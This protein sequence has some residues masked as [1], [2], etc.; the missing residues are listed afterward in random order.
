MVWPMGDRGTCK[1]KLLST[2]ILC[3]CN[4]AYVI[5]I[6]PCQQNN[7]LNIFLC[8][9]CLRHWASAKMQCQGFNTRVFRPSKLVMKVIPESEIQVNLFTN[10][11]EKN[12]TKFWRKNFADFCPLIFRKNGRKK[13]HAKSGTISTRDETKF[14]HHEIHRMT[15]L[16]LFLAIPRKWFRIHF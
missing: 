6:V 11:G 5:V 10:T 15:V 13:F 1:K 4:C 7:S 14:F 2:I 3:N 16:L 9:Q 8:I 12:A